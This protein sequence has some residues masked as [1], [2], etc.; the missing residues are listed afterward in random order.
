MHLLLAYI[1]AQTQLYV[2][3]TTIFVLLR[4]LPLTGS[5]TTAPDDAILT[6]FSGQRGLVVYSQVREGLLL[7]T[8]F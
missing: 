7:F 6:V 5:V 1:K 4:W 2:F 3:C 8:E